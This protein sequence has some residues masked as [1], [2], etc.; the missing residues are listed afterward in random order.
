METRV[1]SLSNLFVTLNGLR[2]QIESLCRV[3]R[4][5]RVTNRSFAQSR[6]EKVG[7]FT[8]FKVIFRLSRGKIDSLSLAKRL[9]IIFA[10]GLPMI[11]LTSDS[12]LTDRQSVTDSEDLIILIIKFTD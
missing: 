8:R 9:S 10:A 2:S 12:S 4:K 5:N 3:Y 11:Q 7:F 6:A 1:F